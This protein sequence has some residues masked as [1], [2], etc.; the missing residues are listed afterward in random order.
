MTAPMTRQT[1]GR[2]EKAD[3][4]DDDSSSSG[5]GGGDPENSIKIM[6]A[7]IT[8]I[9]MSV[10]IEKKTH[11]FITLPF[12]L[13]PS[14]SVSRALFAATRHG[15]YESA[16]AKVLLPSVSQNLWDTTCDIF[17]TSSLL[18]E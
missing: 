1:K 9:I 4:F 5:G 18:F 6:R 14:H 17:L 15:M 3:G 8:I 11:I 12:T 10:F 13:P 2:A 7:P 16:E